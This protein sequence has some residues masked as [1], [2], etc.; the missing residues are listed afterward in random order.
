[1]HI[2]LSPKAC[3]FERII[4]VHLSTP[5]LQHASILSA[6]TLILNV[7][8]P[9]FFLYSAVHALFAKLADS[10]LGHSASCAAI[11]AVVYANGARCLATP[12]AKSIQP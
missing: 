12:Q 7:V 5:G 4:Q 9:Y 11:H 10:L 3:V 8:G 2:E 6:A 1:M